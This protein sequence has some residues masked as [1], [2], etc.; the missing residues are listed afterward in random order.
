MVSPFGV[1]VIKMCDSKNLLSHP[2][3]TD[4]KKYIFRILRDCKNMARLRYDKEIVN[5]FPRN[6]CT[7]N[8]H[9][10]KISVSSYRLQWRCNSSRRHRCHNHIAVTAINLFS[11]QYGHESNLFVLVAKCNK[12]SRKLLTIWRCCSFYAIGKLESLFPIDFF[13]N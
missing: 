3:K 5:N 9:T 8:F 7:R 1:H 2:N 12:L 6:W 4:R 11:L 13:T 10:E